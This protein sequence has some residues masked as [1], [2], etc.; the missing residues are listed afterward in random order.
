MLCIGHCSRFWESYI[1]QEYAPQFVVN[2]ALTISS[3]PLWPSLLLVNF[4]VCL[5][6]FMGRKPELKER[7]EDVSLWILEN[8]TSGEWK[9]LELTT[10]ERTLE[11]TLSIPH[12]SSWLLCPLMSYELYNIQ[13]TTSWHHLCPK[14][15]LFSVLM[16]LIIWSPPP[17]IFNI[18]GHK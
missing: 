18:S 12:P 14:T 9:V 17:F 7:E 3:T 2:F 4:A 1:N 6:Y 15:L 11:G 13:C 5:S 8:K 16:N 10:E